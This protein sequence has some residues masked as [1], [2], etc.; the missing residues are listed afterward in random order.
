MEQ[1][2]VEGLALAQQTKKQNLV[3]NPA[4]KLAFQSIS[5]FF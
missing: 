2:V 1:P 3:E 4:I 5:T